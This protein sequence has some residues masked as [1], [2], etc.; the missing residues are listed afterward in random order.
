[1]QHAAY[2]LDRQIYL[3]IEGAET[4]VRVATS[5][6][7]GIRHHKHLNP[8]AKPSDLKTKVR[9][10]RDAFIAAFRAACADVLANLVVRTVVEPPPAVNAGSTKFTYEG[11]MEILGTSK[12]MPY[13]VTPHYEVLLHAA[14]WTSFVAGCKNATDGSRKLTELFKK[15]P[16]LHHNNRLIDLKTL[17]E[18]LDLHLS[19][20][21][22]RKGVYLTIAGAKEVVNACNSGLVGKRFYHAIGETDDAKIMNQIAAIKTAFVDA[23]DF[24]CAEVVEARRNIDRCMIL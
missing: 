7:L 22:K 12:T 11:D 9:N 18:A 10:I 19:Y 23:L 13:I 14:T 24:K 3:T 17:N 1:M 6:L 15:I 5:G 16:V 2:R 21:V 4:L 8:A 20:K